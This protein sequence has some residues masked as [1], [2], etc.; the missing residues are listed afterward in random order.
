M[1]SIMENT[2]QN[3]PE[4][5]RRLPHFLLMLAACTTLLAQN[6]DAEANYSKKVGKDCANATLNA[7]LQPN[8]EP[9]A[10]NIAGFAIETFRCQVDG[11]SATYRKA[12]HT[13]SMSITDN[14]GTAELAQ[15]MKAANTL[16]PMQLNIQKLQ[17]RTLEDNIRMFEELRKKEPSMAQML[18]KRTPPPIKESFPAGGVLYIKRNVCSAP[19]EKCGSIEAYALIGV[20]YFF[21]MTAEDDNASL[22]NQAAIN[23][24]KEA[25]RAIDWGKLK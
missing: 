25:I 22:T 1:D 8:G 24:A 23:L 3:L 11:S 6:A 19:E 12:D 14:A 20:R 2:K 18:E 4:R 5:V 21:G 15:K 10:A 17:L 9:Q 7:F 16:G 13:I